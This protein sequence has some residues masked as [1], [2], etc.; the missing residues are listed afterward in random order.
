MAPLFIWPEIYLF[1]S[2]K[3]IQAN[4]VHLYTWVT[5]FKTPLALCRLHEQVRSL[6][7]VHC[8]VVVLARLTHRKTVSAGGCKDRQF[9][10]GWTALQKAAFSLN[11]SGKCLANST[12]W[13]NCGAIIMAPSHHHVPI[14]KAF[15][16]KNIL[17][18][19]LRH[20][21][22][23]DNWDRKKLSPCALPL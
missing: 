10:N 19:L 22:F 21:I 7:S 14:P 3:K 13:G 12:V 17:C 1:T 23:G 4:A 2:F 20:L 5:S 18:Q 15:S 8:Y 6:L 9:L 16:D 11:E